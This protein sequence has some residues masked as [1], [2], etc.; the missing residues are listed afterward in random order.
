MPAIFYI[1]SFCS[2]WHRLL[3]HSLVRSELLSSIVKRRDDKRENLEVTLTF[4][5]DVFTRSSVRC[6]ARK[7]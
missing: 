2:L 6:S 4:S 5:F 7:V 3:C 1:T